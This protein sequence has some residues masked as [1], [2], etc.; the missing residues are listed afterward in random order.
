MLFVWCITTGRA[1]EPPAPA[2]A[3]TDQARAKELFDN[4][5]RLYEEGNYDA[6]IVAFKEVLSIT[7]SP[8]IHYNLS[9]CYER[10]GELVAA[11]DH[12]NLYRAVAPAEEQETLDRRLRSL[13]ARLAATPAPSPAPAPATA[14]SPAPVSSST[15][16]RTERSPRW[17]MV[18]LGTGLAATGG[19]GAGAT[20]GM[21]RTAIEANDESGYGTARTLNGV[22]FGV[23]GLG[24]LT[25]LVGLAV[26]VEREVTISVVPNGSGAVVMGGA[27]W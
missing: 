14:A 26:P 17:W 25:A 12:L 1:E 13:E 5:A 21:S 4:G 16:T 18:G 9:N 27:R 15:A 19:V 10:K 6:A 20:Y 3:T 24:A 8:V 2:P 11:R 23:M 7:G 22:S